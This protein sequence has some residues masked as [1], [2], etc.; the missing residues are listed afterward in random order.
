[1]YSFNQ[2]KAHRHSI[3]DLHISLLATILIK[4][5]YRRRRQFNNKII[6]Q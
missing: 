3:I 2:I 1:M 5:K 4:M 6:L